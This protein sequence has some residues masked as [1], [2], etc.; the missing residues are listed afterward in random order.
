MHT[1]EWSQIVEKYMSRG[2]CV[3]T[4]YLSSETLP[5]WLMWSRPTSF[6]RRLTFFTQGRHAY[7]NKPRS[8]ES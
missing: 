6:L 4:W 7:V 3:Y 8:L 2:N 1:R 5:L